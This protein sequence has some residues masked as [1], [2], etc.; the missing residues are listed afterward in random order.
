MNRRFFLRNTLA[1]AA[2]L[3]ASLGG[4][5]AVPGKHTA[6]AQRMRSLEDLPDRHVEVWRIPGR[7]TKN[8][9]L[10]RFPSGKMMLVFCDVEKHWTE[11]ISR[12]T[13]LES[14]DDGKTWGNSRVVAEADVRKG[15]ER[16][17]TPRLS[18]LKDGRLIVI[19]DHDDY[20]HYHEDQSP[21]NWIWFSS[22]EGRTW[23]K[24]HLI[25][26]PGIE[27]DRIVELQDGT[28]LTCATVV[29]KDTQREAMVM[30]RSK[31]EGMQWV[32]L[33]VIAKDFVQNYTEGAIVVLSTGLL[34]CVMRN[35]N[36]NGYPSFVSFSSDQGKSWSSSRPMP[37]SGDRPYAKELSDGR[38]LITYRNRCGNRGTHGWIGDLTQDYGYQIGGTHYGDQVTLEPDTLHIH[39]GLKAVTRYVL[40]PP[41]SFRSDV[42]MATTLRVQG[43]A[44]KPI[45]KMEISRLGVSL[46]ISSSAIWLR[47]ERRPGRSGA[48]SRHSVD[49]TS[50]HRLHLEIKKGLVTVRVDGKPVIYRII[51]DEM[52]LRETW[53]GTVPEDGGDIW[54][55]DF[56]YH[57][58]NQ[59]EPDHLWGWQAR[60][61]KYPDQYQIEHMLELHSNPPSEK[62]RP[63]NGYSSWVELPDGRIYVVDYSNR[64]DPIPT[65]HLYGVYL[66]PEDF[67]RRPPRPLASGKP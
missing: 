29:H 34:A 58:K 62:H 42:L 21:G 30:M 33:T 32:D 22:D 50:F 49:M 12:I 5:Q 38:V 67:S 64:G 18:L 24:P 39:S 55:R 48:D 25:P 63:D 20:T 60:L 47:D 6:V 13:T 14:S 36:H 19:C 41:E 35:E 8:P 54:W 3:S 17:V 45:A 51:R 44:D 16:W 53:F 27:P 31:D 2:G 11:G 37:F 40:L 57:V 28:L 66:S 15:E 52:R 9:D 26:L 65:A 4:A 23:T 56:V 43:P 46:E 61:G 10:I 59:T 7:F 1:G